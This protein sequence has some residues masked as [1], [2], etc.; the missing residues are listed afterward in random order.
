MRGKVTKVVNRFSSASN[1]QYDDLRGHKVKV[2]SACYTFLSPH[3]YVQHR[4][5]HVSPP[6]AKGLACPHPS[7]ASSPANPLRRHDR[8]Q[9]HNLSSLRL[10]ANPIIAATSSLI[11]LPR[12]LGAQGRRQLL[13]ATHSPAQPEKK[14]VRDTRRFR[15]RLFGSVFFFPAGSFFN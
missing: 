7:P 3:F 11:F 6:A 2:V 12:L 14:L 9:K 1:V 13:P 10:I 5:G 15:R 4:K 8:K